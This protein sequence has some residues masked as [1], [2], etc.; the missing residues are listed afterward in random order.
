MNFPLRA[1]A[2]FVVW[3]EMEKPRVSRAS[4]QCRILGTK[5]AAQGGFGSMFKHV[6]GG[7]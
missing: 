7:Y 1:L 3:V 2:Q 4:G 5:K 6:S